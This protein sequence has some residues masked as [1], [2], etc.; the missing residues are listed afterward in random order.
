MTKS[1][2]HA[3]DKF[4]SFSN[5]RLELFIRAS[6]FFIRITFSCLQ[7]YYIFIQHTLTLSW[8]D[9]GITI[10]Y[11]FKIIVM[12]INHFISL[13]WS[14]NMIET[15]RFK[16]FKSIHFWSTTHFLMLMFIIK[17]SIY[18]FNFIVNL[19]LNLIF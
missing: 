1:F 18:E 19:T 12:C 8:K 2:R 3:N 5:N 11:F 14:R 10:L 16:K 13:F 7:I 15:L 4:Y 6:S 9:M 17:N